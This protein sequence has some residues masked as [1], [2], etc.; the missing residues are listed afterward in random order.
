MPK[1]VSINFPF[2]FSVSLQMETIV[3]KYGLVVITR[4]GT[5][6]YKFI[7]ESDQLYKHQVG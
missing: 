7:Y 2:S 3:G 4:A 5:D 6:P 1:I